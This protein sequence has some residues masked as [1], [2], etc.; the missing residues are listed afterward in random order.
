MS[1]LL[2]HPEVV[3]PCHEAPGGRTGDGYAQVT[4]DGHQVYA[5]RVAYEAIHGAI[6]D[7]LVIDH[8]CRNRGC[9]NVD[10]LEAVTHA[11]NIRRGVQ[12]THCVNGHQRNVYV[13]PSTGRSRCRD[14]H[15][16]RECDRKRRKRAIAA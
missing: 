13:M 8:L 14:C 16:E 1:E 2:F 6:P 3:G 4:V 10:H 15:R 7:G 12:M 9:V 5:H 11:E